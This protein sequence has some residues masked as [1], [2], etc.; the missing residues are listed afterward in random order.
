MTR[1]RPRGRPRVMRAYSLS[2][3]SDPELLR[4]LASL[5]AQDRATT[6]TL[7][8]HIAEFDARRL[9][10][11]AAYPSTFA[12]CVHE[13]RLSEEAAFKRIHAARA[14][15]R[16]PAIFGAL[17]EGHLH[18]SGVVMLAPHLTP[19]NAE[20]LL[21]V[22]EHKSKGELEW[23][24]AQRFPR[25]DLPERLQRAPAPALPTDLLSRGTVEASSD[26]HAPG[27]VEAPT[28]RAKVAPLASQRFALQLT[29][30]QSTYEKLRYAQ[31]LLGHALPSDDLAQVLDR[32]LDAL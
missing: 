13:L 28:P 22:A 18:L 21:A 5:V 11:P 16:F 31:Q 27:R 6:A 25:P 4:G 14:A 23:L 20:A 3:L 24:L 7:L 15:R 9:Y 30:G 8:A 2:H 26:Q 29:I 1:T 17:A 32:A 12:Y 10:L 19:E